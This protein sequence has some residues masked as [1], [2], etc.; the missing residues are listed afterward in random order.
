MVC[1]FVSGQHRRHFGN[2]VYLRFQQEEIIIIKIKLKICL[3]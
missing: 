2:S 1:G 3:I